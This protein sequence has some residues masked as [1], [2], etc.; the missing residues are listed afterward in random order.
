VLFTE[1]RV[2]EEDLPVWTTG[3]IWDLLPQHS[4]ASD[5]LLLAGKTLLHP[6]DH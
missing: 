4:V 6:G 2:S 1:M 5:F 3:G